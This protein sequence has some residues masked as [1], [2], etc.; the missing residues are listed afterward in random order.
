MAE[1]GL[2]FPGVIERNARRVII[3]VVLFLQLTTAIACLT[4][5][6]KGPNWGSLWLCL[7]LGLTLAWLLASLH[8]PVFKSVIMLI[9]AG[10]LY[11][12]L[13]PGG[14]DST[15]TLLGL[16]GVRWLLGLF[17]DYKGETIDVFQLS[18]L[19]HN[20][21][22]SMFVIAQRTQVWIKA[23]GSGKP[24][25]DPLAATMAWNGLV[26]IVAIWA[27]WMVEA[28]QNALLAV[29][30]SVML[31]LGTLSAGQNMFS[32]LYL[33]LALTL[34]LMAVVQQ[35]R[36]Q[37][38][39]VSASIA[40]PAHKGR[41]IINFALL[42]TILLVLLSVTLPSLSA[43]RIRTWIDELRK[44]VVQQQ[45][46]LAQ[47]LGIHSEGTPVQDKFQAARSPGLPREHLIGSGPELSGRVVMTVK[48]NNL[49]ALATGNQSLPLYW[50]GFTYDVYTGHGW[51]SSETKDY[52]NAANA[53]LQAD[54][55]EEHLAITEEYFPIESLG[56]TVY[57]AGDPVR[58]NYD[59]EAAW[60]SP[61]DLF[62]IQTTTES[63]YKVV[64][65]VPVADDAALRQSGEIYPDWIRQRFLALPDEVPERVKA[66][67]IRLTAAGITP[68]DRAVAIE[69][70]LRTY[71]YSLNVPQPPPQ[72]DIADYF[73]FD[74][75]KGY[76]DYFAT[77]MVVLARSAGIPARLAIGYATGT[78]NLN[79][80]RFSVTEADAHSWAELYFPG[81]G[82][83]PF[84]AT[85][86]RPVLDRYQPLAVESPA[87][88]G[89]LTERSTGI[90]PK[91]P[92]LW[93]LV[94]IGVL[95]L[96]AMLGA[97]WFGVGGVHLFL[98]PEA[99][100]VAEI[101]KQMKWMA[102]RMGT[103][104]DPG[105]TLY[106]FLAAFSIVI[107]NLAARG[108]RV[109]MKTRLLIDTE[110]VINAIIQNRYQASGYSGKQIVEKWLKLRRWLWLAWAL[111]FIGRIEFRW[112]SQNHSIDG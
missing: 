94:P 57:A 100:W 4:S 82:W 78:Y 7:L 110:S 107:N 108:I 35:N 83:V 12:L 112:H 49:T 53:P 22:N 97:A 60:R 106:E 52:Q 30:P 16:G 86:S 65:L 111:R 80:K 54:H 70:Y 29:F 85:P 89:T 93:F 67:A 36:R 1:H 33:M 55:A 75:K 77:S 41:Q 99:D 38:S 58:V 56:G 81:I 84:E 15:L 17:P 23:M 48:V 6:L 40:F 92:F 14:L 3:L 11:I 18:V 5:A 69:N 90:V 10:I 50:R 19:V 101:Y 39:W 104:V 96:G 32:G 27:G 13:V 62:S 34:M 64:S 28:R 102:V 68:F 43:Q 8:K 42:V 87:P 79:S 88:A 72:L 95:S 51:S 44:P 24:A 26:W 37:Q 73:L 45:S 31:S 61:G 74:L 20:L 47:S 21:T 105:A 103:Q 46:P 9:A 25:F 59:S 98:L 2:T 71:P 76:C 91:V 109:S 63:A 66:L